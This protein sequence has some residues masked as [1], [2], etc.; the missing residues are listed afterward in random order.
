MIYRPVKKEK[1]VIHIDKPKIQA[2]PPVTDYFSQIYSKPN[3]SKPPM[4]IYDAAKALNR[5]GPLSKGGQQCFKCNQSGHW[6][7]D[8]PQ[9]KQLQCFSCGGTG[10]FAGSC[11]KRK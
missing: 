7:R 8:C 9:Q 6:A 3:T 2:N 11:P 1:E 4:S 10:H 5:S